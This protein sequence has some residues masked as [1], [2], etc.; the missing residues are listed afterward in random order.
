MPRSIRERGRLPPITIASSSGIDSITLF[1]EKQS[2]SL[3][4]P[5]NL[6]AVCLFFT[7]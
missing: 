5:F 2:L 7:I 3:A 1:G 4:A 6:I